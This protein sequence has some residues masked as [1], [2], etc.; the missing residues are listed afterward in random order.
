MPLKTESPKK[1][2]VWTE[3]GVTLWL[4]SLLSTLFI[5]V[6][7][8]AAPALGFHLSLRQGT[9]VTLAGVLIS[10]AIVFAGL[11][12]W[13]RRRSVSLRSLGFIRPVRWS[14]VGMG[15]L[16]SLAYAA[17]T[18]TI[19]DVRSHAGEVSIFKVW[20]VFVSVIAAFVE[21]TVF[22]GFILAELERVRSSTWV[23]VIMSGFA[24][25]LLHMGFS[26]WGMVCTTLMGMVLAITYLWSGRSLV[27][28]VVGH[29]L[30]NVIVEPWLLMYV[31]TS[32][33]S[34]FSK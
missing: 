31:I 7:P 23:Q 20:G 6:P 22:R 18:L 32:Y 21:E 14:P 29:T 34:I 12:L 9:S 16:F 25:G 1:W 24:F 17:F 19:P 33:A 13:L 30:I 2:F 26:W 11:A 15:I 4:Y 10:E 8:F 5:A 28:P 3:V 27:A